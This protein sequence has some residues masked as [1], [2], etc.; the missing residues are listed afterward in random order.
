MDDLKA[1]LLAQELEKRKERLKAAAEAIVNSQTAASDAAASSTSGTA[2]P[3]VSK[4]SD[5]SPV[6]VGASP[7]AT[8]DMS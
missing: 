2:S 3:G 7:C 4:R 5:S 8:G 1:D 6:K